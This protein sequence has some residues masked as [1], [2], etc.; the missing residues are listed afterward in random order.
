MEDVINLKQISG[1]SGEEAARILKEEGYNELSSQ[2]RQSFLGMLWRILSEPML[3]LLVGCG[4]LYLFMGEAKDALILLFSVFFIIGITFYQER[5]TEKTLEALKKLSSPRALVIREGKQIR[6]AGREVVKND[7]I[8]IREGDRVPADAVLLSCENLSVDESLLTGESVPVRKVEGSGEMKQSRPGGDDLPFIYSGSLVVSGRGVA[9]VLSTGIKSEIGKIGKSLD[10]IK[11]EDTLLHKE[12]GKI[13]RYVAIVGM[14]LCALVV[15]YFVF[16]RGSFISG[17]LA[18]LTLAMAILPEEFPIVLV[19][20]LTLGAW[21]ISK[22]KVLTRRNAAIETLGAATV[23]CT[24]KTGTLTLNKMELNYLYADSSFCKLDELGS[25]GLSEKFHELLEFGIL[26]S[27]RDPFDPI[28]KELNRIGEM[29]LKNTIHV[30]NKWNL[31]KEYPLTKELLAMSHVWKLANKDDYVVAAKGAPEAIMEL[32]HLDSR[33]KMSILSEIAEMSAKGLRV[34]GVA[35]AKFVKKELPDEQDD[36][37]FDFVGL[38]GFIDPVR[39]KAAGAV[40]EAYTAGMRVIVITGDYPGTAQYVAKKIGIVNPE[41]FLTGEDLDKMDQRELKEKIKTVNIFARI[42][43]EQKL[44]IVNALKE[45]GEIVA[46]TGDGVNDAPALKAAHIGIAMGE[47]GTDVAREAADLVLLNDDFSSIVEAVRLGR[48][49][50]NNLKRAMGYLLG[51]HVPIAGMSI[52]PLFFGYPIA[53]LPAHIVFFEM[54]IDPACAT[55]FESEKEDEDIMKR[56]PRRLNEALFNFKLVLINV[57]QGAGVLLITFMLYFWAINTGKGEIEARS[58]AFTAMVLG[59]M[60]MIIINLSWTKNIV[61]IITEGNKALFIVLSWST[62][63][64]LAVLYIPF[65][66]KLFYLESLSLYS[67]ISVSFLVVLSLSWF[68]A[69]KQFKNFIKFF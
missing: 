58:L 40:S 24:D 15:L 8:I 48:R 64:L 2:S 47:R 37:K 42:V 3:L 32:C 63:C 65:F 66:S 45:N 4:V 16:V 54:V 61:Q 19:V 44:K 38:L 30:H 62:L 28:E 69:L 50:Y 59:N 6:I 57:L 10:L 27:Q 22:R 1:L 29:H 17:L 25:K 26:A 21:R 11:D 46:M 14:F 36:F 67:F 51:V 34:L 31:V 9:K 12:T 55:V 35:K 52:L 13:V 23:L 49:I 20:F 60:L 5:K 56:P 7:I 39:S 33:E 18:G 68:E 41:I 43:P 53:L